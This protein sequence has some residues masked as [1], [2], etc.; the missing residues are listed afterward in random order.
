MKQSQINRLEMMQA[1]NMY[2]NS[3]TVIWSV[4]PIVTTY[5][6]ELTQVIQSIRSNA[7]DQEAS[8]VFIGSSVRQ[9][10]IYIA[11]KMDILDDVL[12]AYADDTA[13]A[14]LLV[15]AS[16]SMSDY[17]RLPNEEFEVKTKHVIQLL[18]TH[19]D[20]MADYGLTQNQ[21]D[22][23]KLTFGSFQDKR[24]KPRSYQIASRVATQSISDLLTEGVSVLEKLDRV[25]KRFKRSN[26]TFYLGYLAARTVIDD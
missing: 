10:K 19:V 5:K 17:L 11:E 7:K 23:V 15:Q 22:D 13:N 21:I 6:N 25:M 8:Q 18:E 1:T 20:G 16:N 24:N 2:L 4:I 3:N 14:E 9:L 12:E 26:A